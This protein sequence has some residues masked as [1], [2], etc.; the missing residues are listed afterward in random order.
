[1]ATVDQQLKKGVLEILVLCII[2]EQDVY[3]YELIKTLE[4]RSD[5]YFVLKEG[6]LYPVM[7]RL[8]DK[9]YIESYRKETEGKRGVPRKYYRIT[10]NGRDNLKE[11]LVTWKQFRDTV[12]VVLK[13]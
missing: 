12:D 3:G 1:M 4:E 5:G 8:E 7:Y 10:D 11:I 6:S 2:E 9:G 13:L